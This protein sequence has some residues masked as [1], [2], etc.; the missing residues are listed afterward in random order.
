M[1]SNVTMKVLLTHNFIKVYFD[2]LNTAQHKLLDAVLADAPCNVAIEA[3]G[4]ICKA[5]QDKLYKV[6]YILSNSFSIELI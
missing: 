1:Q 2:N 4:Y 3:D 6:L 5:K